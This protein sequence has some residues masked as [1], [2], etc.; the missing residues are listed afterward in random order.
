MT[1]SYVELKAASA[2]QSVT[3][4]GNEALY[5]AG[6]AIDGDQNTRSYTERGTSDRW[7]KVNLD[8]MNCVQQVMWYYNNADEPK[9][10]WTCSGD[11]CTCAGSYCSWS[12]LEVGVGTEG[13]GQVSAAGDDASDA[14][15]KRGDA[16]V[17]TFT[18][19]WYVSFSEIKITGLEKGKIS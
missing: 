16:V 5:G 1:V 18:G 6:R 4:D 15:C 3:R 14:A 2:S 8:G 7:L 12:T 10:T 19:S 17:F 13:T 11:G 9:T